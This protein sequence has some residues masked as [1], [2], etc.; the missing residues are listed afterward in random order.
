[1][2]VLAESHR[3][4]ADQ[5]FDGSARGVR[6]GR[7]GEDV[8]FA[9]NYANPGGVVLLS[10]TAARRLEELTAS[11]EVTNHS[12]LD[13]QLQKHGLAGNPAYTAI[14]PP[15]RK[16]F[17]VWLHVTNACNFSCHYCYIPHLAHDIDPESIE[18]VSVPRDAVFPILN[19]LFTFCESRGFSHLHLKFAGGEPSLNRSLIEKFCNEARCYRGPVRVSFGMLSN[20]SFDTKALIP[21][22]V[23]HKIKLSISLDGIGATHDRIR[24]T[25]GH[26]TQTSSWKQIVAAARDLIDAGLPPYFLFTVTAVNY[27]EIDEFADWCHSQRLGFRLS[28][29]RN[30]V[31]PTIGLQEN[32]AAA[33]VQLYRRL[34]ECMPIDLSFERHAR[35]AEWTLTKQKFAA[36][37]SCRN[38][39]ALDHRGGVS[40]CQMTLN[41]PQGNILTQP[42]EEILSRLNANPDLATLTNPTTKSGSCRDCHYFHVCA[43]GCPQ[44]TRQ[45]FGTFERRS[46]WC[47]VYGTVAPVYVEAAARHLLR[48]AKAMLEKNRPS[49]IK[50]G[51]QF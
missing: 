47:F 23:Q 13:T 20:G 43:G 24:H 7:L 31:P 34:G 8:W 16:S 29:V 32:V 19:K 45:A 10:E 14:L 11:N 48:R 15:Q 51:A 25:T 42:M 27:R 1:V 22:L 40:S 9:F 35:F 18:K 21:V 12:E 28:L 4:A 44:H 50:G 38:Y 36:C 6:I 46:P 33:L 2:P 49:L 30:P 37:G 5:P 39:V 17:N 26:G 41:A 3:V